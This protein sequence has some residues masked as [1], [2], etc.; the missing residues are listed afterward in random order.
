[1]PH[2]AQE[3]QQTN[4][5]LSYCTANQRYESRCVSR[6]DVN[7]RVIESDPGPSHHGHG[8]EELSR[9]CDRTVERLPRLQERQLEALDEQPLTS[10]HHV[11]HSQAHGGL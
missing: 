8:G 3:Q 9:V 11:H 1:M 10:L 5:G 7:K 2:A 4:E 6:D